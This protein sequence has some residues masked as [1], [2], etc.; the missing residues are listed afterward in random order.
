MQEGEVFGVFA[1]LV[2]AA[3]VDGARVFVEH[4]G[5]YAGVGVDHAAG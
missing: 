1:G 4:D 3:D 2:A 5:F